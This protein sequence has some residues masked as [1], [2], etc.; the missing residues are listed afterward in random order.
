MGF[1]IQKAGFWKRAAAFLLD[2]VLL[3]IVIAGLL[4][5]LSSLTGYDRKAAQMQEKYDAYSEQY[6]ISLG[7]SE[8]A[9]NALSEADQEKYIAAYNALTSDEEALAIYRE[10]MRLSLL[11]ISL[12]DTSHIPHLGIKEKIFIVV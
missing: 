3:S 9:Y 7:K 8:E 5:V 6:G 2:A 11:C 1:E 10:V 4:S 12:S